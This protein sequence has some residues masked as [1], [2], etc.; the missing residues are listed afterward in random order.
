MK[1]ILNFPGLKQVYDYDCGANA[2]Q[3]VLDYY[4]IDVREGEIMKLSKT[5]KRCGTSISGIKKVLRYFNLKYKDGKM[6]IEKIKNYINKK[7]PVLIIIQA[8]AYEK[9][10]DWKDG[11]YAVVIGYSDKR[12]YFEDPYIG[13]RTYLSYKEFIDRWH[14]EDNKKRKII[15]WGMAVH[16]DKYSRDPHPRISKDY[17]KYGKNYTF[18][19]E[20]TIHMD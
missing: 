18:K 14:D 13:K 3:G 15:N 19:E 1:K 17:K 7:I 12:I 6:N 5:S 4:G 16:R 11:H 9:K 10:K 20:Q 2:V 8:W